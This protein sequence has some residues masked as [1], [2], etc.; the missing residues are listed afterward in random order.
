[1]TLSVRHF[2]GRHF[3]HV[4]SFV[5]ANDQVRDSGAYEAD[6]ARQ[7]DE[8]GQLRARSRKKIGDEK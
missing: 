6:K 8:S 7:M 1:M 5:A 3:A 4:A 2:A